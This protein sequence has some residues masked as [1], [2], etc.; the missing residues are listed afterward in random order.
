MFWD[1][2]ACCG[3]EGRY[4]IQMVI[5][6]MY[7]VEVRNSSLLLF[8]EMILELWNDYQEILLLARSWMGCWHQTKAA[9]MRGFSLVRQPVQA[10]PALIIS[11]HSF[12][13]ALSRPHFTHRKTLPRPLS[14]T[15]RR[16]PS[17]ISSYRY[18]VCLKIWETWNSACQACHL[19]TQCCNLD[20]KER[21]LV[22]RCRRDP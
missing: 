11:T 19:I 7:S 2:A 17:C 4:R 3:T 16:M 10:S 20:S 21:M 15:S 6:N 12:M 5:R 1:Q 14:H 22:L 9:K 18:M 13:N 8:M